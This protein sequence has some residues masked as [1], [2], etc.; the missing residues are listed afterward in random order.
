MVEDYAPMKGQDKTPEEKL[1]EVEIGNLSEKEFRVRIVKMI[2]DLRKGMETHIKY[3]QEIFNKELEEL[4]NR[5][6]QCNKWNEKNV[7]E[8]INNRVTEAE[9]WMSDIEDRMIEITTM[10]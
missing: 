10:K 7:L 8:V 4:K 1:S 3:I 9:E 2:Q 6:E 5:D